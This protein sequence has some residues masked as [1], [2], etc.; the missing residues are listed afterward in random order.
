[1]NRTNNELL[2]LDSQICFPLYAA[3]R[4]VNKQYHPFLTELNLTY[5]Q[6]LVMLV[7]WEKTPLSEKEMGIR[8][9]LDSGTLT[10][11]LKSLET[12]GFIVRSRSREDERVVCVVLT[13]EGAA[14]KEKA[15][16]IPEAIRA[17]VPLSDEE[18]AVLRSLLRKILESEP[19]E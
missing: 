3:S 4:E 11:V 5:T 6:Y 7:L 18:A 13:E 19:K 9:H 12:K 8:L 10:P 2:L 16:H 1:M 14:M 15:A 17:S